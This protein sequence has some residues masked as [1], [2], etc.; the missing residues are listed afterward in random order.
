MSYKNA[1][2]EGDDSGQDV[3]ELNQQESCPPSSRKWVHLSK[4]VS[5]SPSFSGRG[6]NEE[7]KSTLTLSGL[8]GYHDFSRLMK[9]S[10]RNPLLVDKGKAMSLEKQLSHE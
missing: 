1:L 7:A 6:P 5:R 2:A 3:E 4:L 10:H 8:V 9:P